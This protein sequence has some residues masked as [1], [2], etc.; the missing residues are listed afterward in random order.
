[1]KKLKDIISDI[2]E[3]VW[4]I[5]SNDLSSLNSPTADIFYVVLNCGPDSMDGSNGQDCG[6]TE[7]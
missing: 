1:M 2:D 6:F 3:S 5:L 7:S 4:K